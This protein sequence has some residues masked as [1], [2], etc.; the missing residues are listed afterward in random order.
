MVPETVA[1]E[2]ESKSFIPQIHRAQA[3]LLEDMD[4]VADVLYERV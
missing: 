1:V 2:L 4:Y 3:G